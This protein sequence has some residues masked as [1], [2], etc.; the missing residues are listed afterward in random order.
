MEKYFEGRDQIKLKNEY[1]KIKR[2]EKNQ[3]FVSKNTLKEEFSY[4]NDDILDDF[5]RFEQLFHQ[6]EILETYFDDFNIL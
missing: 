4:L 1:R 3:C 5:P 2:N 6:N